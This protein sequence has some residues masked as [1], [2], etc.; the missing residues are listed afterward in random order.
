[1]FNAVCISFFYIL[2]VLKL[3]DRI[4]SCSTWISAS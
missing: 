2:K 1:M 3:L 4:L